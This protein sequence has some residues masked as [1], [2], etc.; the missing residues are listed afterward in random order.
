R[1]NLI[2]K[3]WFNLARNQTYF[4]TDADN[5]ELSNITGGHVINT[6]CKDRHHREDLSCKMAAEYEAYMKSGNKWWCHFDDDNYV[7]VPLLVK[8]LD[9][10]DYNEEIYLGKPSLSRPIV[11]MYK[12][13]F[14][15]V[16]FAT[17]GA[18]LCVSS[19]LAKKMEPWCLNGKF[20]ETSKDLRLPDD[21][22]L[23]F[24]IMNRL[25]VNLTVSDLFHS[26]LEPLS[27]LKPPVL[28]HQVSF[29]YYQNRVVDIATYNTQ[30]KVFNQTVDPTR[31]LSIH[32]CLFPDTE[33]C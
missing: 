31:F 10:F 11:S 25:G 24:I 21:C 5:S 4:F 29:S 16:M 13:G 33:F 20:L 3:T 23:G 12:D 7:N 2:I 1:I 6:G 22:T 18:G 27:K 30:S 14:V 17:G 28:R 26:H 9:G 32:C 19:A 15:E 8:I